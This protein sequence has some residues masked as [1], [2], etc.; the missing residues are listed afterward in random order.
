M[1]DKQAIIILGGGMVKD[2]KVW[3][4]MN[5]DEGTQLG[6]LGDKLRVEAANILYN[7]NPKILLIASSGKGMYKDVVDAPV[8]AEVIKQELIDLG[9]EEASILT[10]EKSDNTYQQLQELK[11]IINEHN[12]S[13][14]RIISNRYHV[15]RIKAMIEKDN[16]LRALSEQKKI[17]AVSAEEVLIKHDLKQWKDKIDKAYESKEM[18]K[19]ITI[20]EQGVQDIKSGIYKFI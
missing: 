17:Q 9:V 14:V 3:R 16:E 8:P 10:E 11:K 4:T 2:G 13:E 15:P 18:K 6:A 5:L 19:R 7:E 12:L 1:P 20:E